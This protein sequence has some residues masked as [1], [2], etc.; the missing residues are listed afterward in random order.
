[1]YHTLT[2]LLTDLDNHDAAVLQ[3]I[4]YYLQR[5]EYDAH[6]DKREAKLLGDDESAGRTL[7]AENTIRAVRYMV[8]QAKKAKED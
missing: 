8:A 4:E 7:A 1:M 5:A 2:A 3:S 6:R